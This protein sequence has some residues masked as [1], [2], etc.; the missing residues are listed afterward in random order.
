MAG[1]SATLFRL[2]SV[3]HFRDLGGHATATGRAV[4]RGRLYRSGDFSNVTDAD[5]ARLHALGITAVC[6]LRSEDERTRSPNRWPQDR[7]AKVI[8]LNVVADLR[9][10]DRR[11]WQTLFSN[12][13]R[14][15]AHETMIRVYRSMPKACLPGLPLL[16]ESLLAPEGLPAVIHCTAGKDRTGFVSA[17]LLLALGVPRETVYHD[18]LLS[19]EFGTNER[20]LGVITRELTTRLG[21]VPDPEAIRPLITVEPDY[22]DAALDTV[23]ADYGSL[24]AYLAQAGGIDDAKLAHL[25]DLLLE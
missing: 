2:E 8:A 18:Y 5:C 22:L 23:A 19:T 4:R 17:V 14:L 16:M 25:H 11:L 1:G 6:D 12:F 3:F 21:M 24:E 7:T 10:G 15:G 13:T 20:A 9:A